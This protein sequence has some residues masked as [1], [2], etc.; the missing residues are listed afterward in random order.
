[1]TNPNCRRANQFLRNAP[2]P[3]RNQLLFFTHVEKGQHLILASSQCIARKTNIN[4]LYAMKRFPPTNTCSR[5]AFNQIN[6]TF[7]HSFHIRFGSEMN[8]LNLFVFVGIKK[9]KRFC[10]GRKMNN[11]AVKFIHSTTTIE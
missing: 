3:I 6:L 1:M 11:Y 9:C 2:K 8:F 10:H 7:F 4:C 5:C